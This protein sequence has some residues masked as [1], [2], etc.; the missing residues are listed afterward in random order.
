MHHRP[1]IPI[2]RQGKHLLTLRQGALLGVLLGAL[3]G[4]LLTAPAPA[5]DAITSAP[6][7]GPDPARP[8]LE[9]SLPGAVERALAS[10]QVLRQASEA[11]TA[12]EAAVTAAGA[13]RLPQLDLAGEWSA[14]LKKPAF[15]LPPEFG[16][17]FGGATKVE[18]GRDQALQG[19]ATLSWNLW[20]AGRLSAAVGAAREVVAASRWQ[21]DAAADAVRYQ[22]TAAYLDVLLADARVAIAADARRTTAEALRIAE[23]GYEQGTVSEFALLRARVELANRE[24]P[25]IQARNARR[26]AELTLA[27]TCGLAPEAAVQLTDTLRTVP[28]PAPTDTL[29]AAMRRHS[30]ELRALE[31][32]VAA[33]RQSVAL[34]RAGRGPVVQL[35]GEYALQAEWDDDLVPDARERAFSASAG[36]AVSVPIFDGLQS[37]AEI[38][39]AR[40]ELRTAELELERIAADRQ[41]A[42]RRARLQLENARAA[43][44]GRREGVALAAEAYRLAVVRLENGLATPLERLDAELALTDARVQL[45]ESLHQCNLARAALRLAVGTDLDARTTPASPEDAR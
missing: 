6:A 20:T 14:N 44:R 30:P 22:A 18:M 39:G 32:Q 10:D 1:A 42:V 4:A 5:S 37:R 36:V 16:A 21:R 35:R 33:A 9:L 38:R 45:A 26:Q 17:G 29:L 15:F 24:A 23:A 27:R 41:L 8:V 2:A 3:L 11:V 25:L 40:A 43:L 19:A 28:A 12:A 31:R 7:T 13:G 34:A